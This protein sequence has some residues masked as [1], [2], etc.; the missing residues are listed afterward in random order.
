MGV[1]GVFVNVLMLVFFPV[2]CCFLRLRILRVSRDCIRGGG[3]AL[4]GRFCSGLGRC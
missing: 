4:R 3:G 2:T 1:G